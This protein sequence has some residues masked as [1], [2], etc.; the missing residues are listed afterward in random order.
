MKPEWEVRLK[1]LWCARKPRDDAWRYAVL[2]ATLLVVPYQ[3]FVSLE[4]AFTEEDV[5][6]TTDAL[7]NAILG[8][9]AALAG[10]EVRLPHTPAR[11]R[12]RRVGSW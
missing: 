12:R 11:A 6:L 2:N 8:I 1:E 3:V 10:W 5:I 7:F 4:R 9:H